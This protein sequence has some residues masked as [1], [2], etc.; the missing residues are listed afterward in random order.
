AQA[1][2]AEIAS[3]PVPSEEM[4]GSVGCTDPL[5]RE[6]VRR[7]HEAEPGMLATRTPAS[8]IARLIQRAES[9]GQFVMPACA[10]QACPARLHDAA[11]PTPA[12]RDR[13]S[14]PIPTSPRKAPDATRSPPCAL[15]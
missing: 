7:H 9:D 11:A 8:Q 1:H 13:C 6:S 14:L 4:L 10:W 12:I 3:H 2:K 15:A 5:W